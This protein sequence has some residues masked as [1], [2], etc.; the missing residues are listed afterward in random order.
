MKRIF[1]ALVL[2]LIS[3]SPIQAQDDNLD[4]TTE[5]DEAVLS[6]ESPAN[7]EEESTVISNTQDYF[8]LRLEITSQK[9]LT[10]KITITIFIT[11]KIEASRTQILWNIPTV[12]KVEKLHKEFVS[13]Q[14]DKTYS[15]QA[16]LEPL[17]SGNYDISATIISWQHDINKANSVSQRL[18]LNNS[19]VVQPIQASYALGLIGIFIGILGGTAL[20]IFGS[21]KGIKLLSKKAKKWLTP[22]TV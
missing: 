8:D 15:Y 19:L 1:L 17:R 4:K 11:P 13:L 16:I 5:V 3:F 9:P 7:E 12:F 20:I 22:P 18:E 21:I 14:K 6:D 10:K 2:I